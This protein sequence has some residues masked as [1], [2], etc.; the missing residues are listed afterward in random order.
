MIKAP[1][2]NA[3]KWEDIPCSW[4][5]RI[6]TVKMAIIPK[7]I[8][9]FNAISI[10]TPMTFFTELKQKIIKFSEDPQSDKAILRKKKKMLEVSSLQTPDYTIKLQQ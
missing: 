6:N 4:V 9:K 2:G 3:K 1:E 8:Y 7:A 5:G 10:K